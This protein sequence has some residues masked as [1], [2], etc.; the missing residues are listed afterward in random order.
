MITSFLKGFYLGVGW[1]DGITEHH[2]A[3]GGGWIGHTLI[4]DYWEL[5]LGVG[6]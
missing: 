3:M 2:G 6:D 5:Y 1:M 4:F